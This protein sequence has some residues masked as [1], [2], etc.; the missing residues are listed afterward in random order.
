MVS[1]YLNQTLVLD[2]VG[3]ESNSMPSL[4]TDFR[5][6]PVCDVFDFLIGRRFTRAASHTSRKRGSVR[7]TCV[8]PKLHFLPVLHPVRGGLRKG[9]CDIREWRGC[10]VCYLYLF[11]SQGL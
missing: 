2:T 11:T 1:Q 4:S 8:D 6:R 9:A 7:V 5:P 10:G 3:Y